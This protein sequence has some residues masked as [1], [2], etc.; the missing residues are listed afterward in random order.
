MSHPPEPPPEARL[1]E[2]PPLRQPDDYSCGPTCLY[3]VLK[4]YGDARSFAEVAALVR[5][6]DNGG[7]LGVFLGQA[8][9]ALGYDATLYSYNLRVCDPT[10]AALSPAVLGD[11]LAAR[12]AVVRERKLRE[13]VDAYS[14]FV[15]SGGRVRFDDLSVELLVSILDGGHPIVCGLSATY[16]YQTPRESPQSS[17]IDD[18]G[19]EPEGHFLVV[20]GYRQYGKHFVVSDPYRGL[21]MTVNGTYEVGAQ[22]L[23]NAVLLG[24]VTY[25]GVLLVVAPRVPS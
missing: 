24:D 7:T 12:A 19:G 21:P 13:A 17:A 16:L 4:G 18:V 20:C 23:L 10:W 22:R 14:T 8:A 1:L 9:L 5:R 6:N 25:D 3:K 15:R 11:K 2:V